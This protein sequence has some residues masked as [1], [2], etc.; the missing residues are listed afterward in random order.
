MITHYNINMKTFAWRL[1]QIL[2]K[3]IF[4]TF[5]RFPYKISFVIILGD[6]ACYRKLPIFF[7]PI[8]IQN[9]DV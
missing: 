7:Q 5:S 1:Y 4:F 2:L 6:I 9:Y 3:A 8:I